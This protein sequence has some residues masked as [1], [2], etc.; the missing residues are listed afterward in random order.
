MSDDGDN[1]TL[2]SQTNM[3]GPGAESLRN[4]A[5][6]ED[7]PHL[8]EAKDDKKGEKKN[9]CKQIFLGVVATA[10]VYS[11]LAVIIALDAKKDNQSG[12]LF[13]INISDMIDKDTLL[14]VLFRYF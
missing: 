4:K 3:L 14:D 2:A 10:F 8:H 1:S 6:T 12:T 7:K 13:S 9:Y 11:M 5:W